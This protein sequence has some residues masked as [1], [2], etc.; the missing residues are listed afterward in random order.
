MTAD[1][2][3]E[4]TMAHKATSARKIVCIYPRHTN[5]Y[6]NFS[7]AFRF[8]PDTKAL[9]PPLGLLIIA[10]YLPPSWSIRFID[11]D[12]RPATDDDYRWADVV[13]TSGTHSQLHLLTAIAERARRLGKL[14][15][16]GG[17]AASA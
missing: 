14:S 6:P 1:T 16:I 11:E 15:V 3:L 13:M 4:V 9:M 10:S 5:G 8:F 7:Y 2:R 12:V 17:P